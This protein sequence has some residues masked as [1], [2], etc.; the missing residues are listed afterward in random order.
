MDLT[1]GC[2]SEY[3]R[4]NPVEESMKDVFPLC[5]WENIWDTTSTKGSE[6]RVLGVCLLLYIPV[7]KEYQ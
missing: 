7:S 5:F 1:N 3:E 6:G 4:E 2:S